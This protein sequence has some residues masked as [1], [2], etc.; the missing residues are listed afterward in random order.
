MYHIV[1]SAVFAYKITN[2][3]IEFY[4]KNISCDIL[5]VYQSGQRKSPR[6]YGLVWIKIIY[7]HTHTH[8][9]TY[10]YI[11]IYIYI[12]FPFALWPHLWHQIIKDTKPCKEAILQGA[13]YPAIY[14]RAI[15]QMTRFIQ[16]IMISNGEALFPPCYYKIVMELKSILNILCIL[17]I[18]CNGLL[19]LVPWINHLPPVCWSTFW[20]SSDVMGNNFSIA[21][22]YVLHI[23][24]FT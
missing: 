2:Q 7:T 8:T 23:S 14:Q 24:I 22:S 11:Y 16:S 6:Q 13:I 5:H 1:V 15:L 10:I 21:F 4:G 19:C 18:F 17:R 9:H 12:C 20:Q 3:F